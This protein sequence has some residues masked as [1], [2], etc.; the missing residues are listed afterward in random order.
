MVALINSPSSRIPLLQ[1]FEEVRGS[2]GREGE[3]LSISDRRMAVIVEDARECGTRR[4][5]WLRLA[6]SVSFWLSSVMFLFEFCSWLLS[7]AIIIF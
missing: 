2:R 3:Y 5:S 6:L 4:V 1:K 7:I